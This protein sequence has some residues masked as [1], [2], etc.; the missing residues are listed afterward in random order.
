MSAGL[1]ELTRQHVATLFVPE[2]RATVEQLLIEECGNNLPFLDKESPERLERLRFAAL[3]MSK[4][5]LNELR[6]AIAV[7]KVDW[8]DLLVGAGFG[9]DVNA[10][11]HWTPKPA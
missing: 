5:D 9:N 10:H 1:T 11:L 7:A 2:L 3:K 4:G 6:E 8:R